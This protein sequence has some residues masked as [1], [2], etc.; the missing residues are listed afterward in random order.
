[1]VTP[2]ETWDPM[3]SAVLPLCLQKLEVDQGSK[4]PWLKGKTRKTV[5]V[6]TEVAVKAEVTAKVEVEAK[7]EAAV[8][9][10]AGN[11]I[12]YTSYPISYMCP[13]M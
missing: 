8:A 9:V 2:A 7:V 11:F 1:M 3:A 4:F 10:E 6:E 13:P 5:W 12:L